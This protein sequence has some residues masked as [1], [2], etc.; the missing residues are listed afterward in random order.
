[1]T[2]Y[3]PEQFRKILKA[4]QAEFIEQAILLARTAPAAYEGSLNPT[5]STEF[6]HKTVHEALEHYADLKADG[7]TLEHTVPVLYNNLHSFVA[8][9]PDHVFEADKALIAQR[10][11]QAYIKEVEA[12]NK[13]TQRLKDKAS[14]VESEFQRLEAKRQADLRAELEEQ[15]NNRGRAQ[16]VNSTDTHL[17]AR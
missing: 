13:E 3:A 4:E 1:M 6:Y 12:H 10:A 15:Y 17:H 8:I 7:W 2:K 16:Y 14:Y 9:K 11:E 5:G